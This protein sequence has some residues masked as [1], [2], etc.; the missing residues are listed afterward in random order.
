MHYS[1]YVG[2][3]FGAVAAQD[4]AVVLNIALPQSTLTAVGSNAGATTYKN[5]CPSDAAG[6]S[7]VPSELRK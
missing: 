3:F 5:S 2:L 7:A 4:S 1:T 6:I